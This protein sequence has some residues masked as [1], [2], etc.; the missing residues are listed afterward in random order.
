MISTPLS[1]LWLPLSLRISGSKVKKLIFNASGEC[2]RLFLGDYIKVAVNLSVS[3][4]PFVLPFRAHAKYSQSELKTREL[5]FSYCCFD[6]FTAFNFIL[7]QTWLHI[8]VYSTVKIDTKGAVRPI[9]AFSGFERTPCNFTSTW[10]SHSTSSTVSCPN[11]VSHSAV[12]P[13][14]HYLTPLI[15][16]M[17]V[18]TIH[19]LF[20]DLAL[21]SFWL[22]RVFWVTFVPCRVPR[23]PFYLMRWLTGP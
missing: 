10:S 8:F 20:A 9:R 21:V 12:S 3:N 14:H 19:G 11:V 6:V 15:S 23:P 18:K 16:L 2:C 5:I 1:A 22:T 17:T 13:F 7:V 4:P